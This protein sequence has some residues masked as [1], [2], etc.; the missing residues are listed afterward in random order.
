M[1]LPLSNFPFTLRKKELLCNSISQA[2]FLVSKIMKLIR[3]YG[4]D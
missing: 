2:L 3:H 1:V 4:V